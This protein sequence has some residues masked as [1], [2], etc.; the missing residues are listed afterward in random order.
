MAKLIIDLKKH[1][2]N[3][4]ASHTGN[5]QS[6]LRCLNRLWVQVHSYLNVVNCV[7]FCLVAI[8]LKRQSLTEI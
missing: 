1:A 6:V 5:T 3:V 7:P 4:R 8:Q 2:L